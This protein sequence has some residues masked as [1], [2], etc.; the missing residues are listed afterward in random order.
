MT[1]VKNTINLTNR[2]AVVTGGASGIGQ[3]TALRL[4]REGH[5]VFAGMRNLGKAAGL[6]EQAGRYFQGVRM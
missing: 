5:R 6:R 2:S 3:A 4:A 1:A